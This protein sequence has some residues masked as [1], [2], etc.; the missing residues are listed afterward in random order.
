MGIL[1]DFLHQEGFR[2]E[3]TF[4]DGKKAGQ[5]DKLF[6]PDT[7]TLESE[8]TYDQSGNKTGT[9]TYYYENKRTARVGTVR[10]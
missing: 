6:F 9:W 5:M 3:G 10:K 2:K 1:K 8:K 7:K 4:R